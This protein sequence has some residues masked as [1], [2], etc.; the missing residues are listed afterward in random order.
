MINSNILTSNITEASVRS[1]WFTTDYFD[2]EGNLHQA[3]SPASVAPQ[4]KR[5]VETPVGGTEGAIAGTRIVSVFSNKP[6][7]VDLK[8]NTIRDDQGRTVEVTDSNRILFDLAW[9]QDNFGDSTN[10]SMMVDNKVLT[11]DGKVL[12]RSK[13]TY[14]SGQDVKD[15]IAGRKKE[16]EDRVAKSKEVISEIYENQKRIDKTRTDGEFYY[17]LEDD[18]EYH[19]YS[20]VHSRLG[21]N[22]VESPKQ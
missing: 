21:S 2:N 1:N 11:P 16:R 10:S 5:K 18:G 7:Y 13:Q 15:T 20:R 14:L 12:D 9:A 4:P 22:W 6:Y 8:T 3:I 19:Q 17:V